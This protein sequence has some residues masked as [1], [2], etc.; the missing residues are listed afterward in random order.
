MGT[1]PLLLG[2]ISTLMRLEKKHFS[3]APSTW[4]ALRTQVV[5]LTEEFFFQHV[6]HTPARELILRGLLHMPR[7]KHLAFS[8]SDEAIPQG[9]LLAALK[10][11][12]VVGP[13]AT[14]TTDATYFTQVLQLHRTELA[15]TRAVFL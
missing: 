2:K 14:D 7:I 8:N 12:S 11:H 9:F 1:L 5:A 4:D 3:K 15:R 6:F 13:G 10:Q